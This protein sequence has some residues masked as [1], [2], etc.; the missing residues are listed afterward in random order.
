MLEQTLNP[1]L[2]VDRGSYWAPYF[3]YFPAMSRYLPTG[4]YAQQ[5]RPR[6]CVL[7][8]S[9]GK[10][11]LPL[12]RAGWE[13]VGVETDELFLDGGELHL[14]DGRHEVVGLRK[15]LADEGLEDRCTI[16]EQD[17]M[18]LPADGGF[19][20]VMGSGL[21]SMPSNRHHTLQA[22]FDHAMGMVAP[23]GIFFAD[24]LIGLNPE[25]RACG[26]YPGL[27]EMERIVARDG[28]EVFENADLGIYG[29]SHVGF[30]QWHYHR[31]AAIV[32]HRFHAAAG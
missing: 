17:Y 10:F 14:V 24:W 12:L 29:E 4:A 21:W 32:A 27:D 1:P 11:A 31:Y 15:R 8:A 28:W 20:F 13:V 26:Y 2:E 18:T 9:D 22:L 25:E 5:V 16:V 30:E 6:A 23:G 19:Q 3:T 7:G